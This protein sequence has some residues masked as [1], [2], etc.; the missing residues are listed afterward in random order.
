M[1]VLLGNNCRRKNHKGFTLVELLVAMSVIIIFASLTA[2]FYPG[3]KADN[4]ISR[5]SVAVQS[6]FVG[7]RQR[8]KRDRVPTGI[9]LQFDADNR[10][11]QLIIVQKPDDLN[12]NTLGAITAVNAGLITF[13]QQ[14]VQ[15]GY[16][17]YIFPNDL[18]VNN[19]TGESF[20][21]KTI[22]NKQ[23]QVDLTFSNPSFN[24]FPFID[25]RVIRLPRTIP[26]E[27]KV[28]IPDEYE[29]SLARSEDVR[30]NL[31][32]NYP[33]WDKPRSNLPL[34]INGSYD[35]LFDPNG[36]VS[37]L[38]QK[39]DVV[40]WLHKF[41]N[42][43][44]DFSNDALICIRKITGKVGTFS[45]DPVNKSNPNDDSPFGLTKDP[46]NEGL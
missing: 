29:I 15:A 23:V 22:V 34:A 31:G 24:Y 4:A 28:D 12:Y 20:V 35:I 27:N 46:R 41:T 43:P 45:V 6:N 9:R 8:A 30:N 40:L 16:E 13:Q 11:T 19:N 36:S 25:F 33:G 7:A 3:L 39:G 21:A 26:G 2:A 14:L 17:D 32:N 44:N 10:C 38:G 18:I 42:Q 1:I 5:V 37:S